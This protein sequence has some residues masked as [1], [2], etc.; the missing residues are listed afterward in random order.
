MS[1]TNCERT[2]SF[3]FPVRLSCHGAAPNEFIKSLKVHWDLPLHPECI[4]RVQGKTDKEEWDSEA[5]S[6]HW[7]DGDNIRSPKWKCTPVLG[8]EEIR[9]L[10]SFMGLAFI[11]LLRSEEIRDKTWYEI[12]IT[13][14]PI[15]PQ[16]ITTETLRQWIIPQQRAEWWRQRE[17][18]DW[19][20]MRRTI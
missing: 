16:R 15:S 17:Q 14:I 11:H 13:L 18:R 9:G 12:F 4:L 2:L 1:S 19:K 5:Y 6:F 10:W 7:E 20:W 8:T 3:L